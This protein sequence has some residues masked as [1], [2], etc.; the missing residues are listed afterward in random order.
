M[1]DTYWQSVNMAMDRLSDMIDYYRNMH[2]LSLFVDRNRLKAKDY[3]YL[4]C[5]AMEKLKKYTESIMRP[6]MRNIEVDFITDLDEWLKREIAN[7]GRDDK[8]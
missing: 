3:W 7:I 1:N 5:E 6:H 8:E 2:H 4:Y